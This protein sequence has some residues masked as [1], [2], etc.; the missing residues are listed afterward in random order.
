MS[1]TK[2]YMAGPIQHSK[3]N[4]KGWRERVKDKYPEIDWV[5]PIDKYDSSDE[6]AEWE[7][8]KIV[9]EDKELIDDCDGILL[10][11]EKVASWGTPREQEYAKQTDKPVFVQTTVPPEEQ[12]PWLTVDAECVEP[13]FE[14]AIMAIKY[15]FHPQVGLQE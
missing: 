4:G 5:D 12:S 7:D 11:Y 8:E 3:S 2:I 15:H 14:D 9:R 10:H 6:A 1:K 13:M